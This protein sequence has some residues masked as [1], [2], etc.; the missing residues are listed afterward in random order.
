M[1][2]FIGLLI[3]LYVVLVLKVRL[4]PPSFDLLNFNFKW[5]FQIWKE[6]VNKWR[7]VHGHNLLALFYEDPERW[8]MLLQ[9]Y[10]QLTIAQISSIPQVV[11]SHIHVC[12]YKYY[13]NMLLLLF[14]N[15]L[16]QSSNKYLI[17]HLLDVS[18]F[19]TL[20]RDDI[21]VVT[22]ADLREGSGGHM[23]PGASGQ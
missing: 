18:N 19:V 3:V 10:V 17:F 9:S 1:F 4:T 14:F 21:L 7:N 6:P 12:L 8:S 23:S 11:V 20:N 16:S 2:V 5:H 13:F 22:E 15:M